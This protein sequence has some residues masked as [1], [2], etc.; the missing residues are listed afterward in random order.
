MAFT[1]LAQSGLLAFG[2]GLGLV[3]G[4]VW[5][6]RRF[7]FG[8]DTPG[9]HRLHTQSIPRIG[10]VAI[11]GA[12]VLGSW[13]NLWPANLLNNQIVG[14]MVTALLITALGFVDDLRNLKPRTKLFGQIAVA[15]LAV[16]GF[17][18]LIPY[19][20][21]PLGGIIQ[22]DYLV[23]VLVSL[24]WLVSMPNVVNLLDG[25]DGLAT[26]ILAIFSLVLLCVAIQ[27][28]QVE[29]GALAAALLGATGAFL[30]FNF[31]P[32]KIFMGDSGSLF[33]GIVAGE[34]SI[35]AGAKLATVML[36]LAI[37]IIDVA[38]TILRRLRQGVSIARRDTDHFHHRLLAMGLSPR[39]VCYVYYACASVF[40]LVTLIPITL[41][42]V[43]AMG[44]ACVVYVGL[45]AYVDH[46]IAEKGQEK[47]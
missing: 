15:G 35:L 45:L 24:A 23:S 31:N 47:K 10:G 33:L 4:L 40:G 5:L 32:A 36:V 34:L 7:N 46:K 14:V 42:K 30:V 16:L 37:P 27:F 11:C 38:Y 26:G 41:L 21:N 19:I 39:Q 44:V 12:F 43:L 3:A 20:N 28:N 9:P 17:D 22:F 18:I 29:L 13:L 6:T 25:V 2:I 1:L 8:M